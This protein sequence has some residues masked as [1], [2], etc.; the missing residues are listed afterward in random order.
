MPLRCDLRCMSCSSVQRETH[1]G[2]CEQK[3][4]LPNLLGH[5]K[6]WLPRIIIAH[7]GLLSCLLSYTYSTEVHACIFTTCPSCFYLLENLGVSSGL[8][9]ETKLEQLTVML[10][11]SD[12]WGKTGRFYCCLCPWVKLK[13]RKFLLFFYQ[14]SGVSF[15]YANPF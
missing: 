12:R 2:A 15:T 6:L 8:V 4:S 13:H 3:C 5:M 11:N 1:H 10:Q 14:L 7:W 9:L